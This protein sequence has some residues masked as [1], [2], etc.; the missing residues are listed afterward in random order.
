MRIFFLIEMIEKKCN[1]FPEFVKTHQKKRRIENRQRWND[2]NFHFDDFFSYCF[3]YLFFLIDDVFLWFT[4]D[5]TP[6]FIAIIWF[7][8]WCGCD[9]FYS[10]LFVSM[11]IIMIMC[12]CCSENK[13]T[14]YRFFNQI[15][16]GGFQLT[17]F[18]LFSIIFWN[19]VDELSF[20]SGDNSMMIIKVK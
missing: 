19:K 7:F 2:I 1:T 12:C 20:F 8:F 4:N 3:F 18:C 13:N 11:L 5:V 6:F 10:L 14:T 9:F 15:S 16:I 17:F